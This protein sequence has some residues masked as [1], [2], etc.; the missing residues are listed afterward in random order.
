MSLI[1]FS[2]VI[3]GKLAGSSMPGSN[4]GDALLLQE[5]IGQLAD[6]GIKHLIS[7]ELPDKSLTLLCKKAG[8]QWQY[9]YIPDFGI[10]DN[11]DEFNGMIDRLLQ[12]IEQGD[13]VCVHCRAGIGRTGM[14]LTCAVGKLYMLGYKKAIDT[15]RRTR[16]AVETQ[17]QETFIKQYLS[18]YEQ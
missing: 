17:E 7:L 9:F 5:D 12:S 2:W 4:S 1:N 15:V 8:I 13:T 10:P 16:K 11:V 6:A 3:P 14:V 18:E